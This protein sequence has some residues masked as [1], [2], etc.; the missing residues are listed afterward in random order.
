MKSARWQNDNTKFQELSFSSRRGALAN[1]QGRPLCQPLN[2]ISPKNVCGAPALVESIQLNP[3]VQI[4]IY[5]INKISQNFS[6]MFVTQNNPLVA[7][8]LLQICHRHTTVS[9]NCALNFVIK[10]YCKNALRDGLLY[11]GERKRLADKFERVAGKIMFHKV[12]AACHF[13]LNATKRFFQAFQRRDEWGSWGPFALGRL[14]R[15]Y[16]SEDVS[17]CDFKFPLLCCR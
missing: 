4:R 17:N 11:C 1:N 8:I 2:Y 13:I 9:F 7:I 12:F 15:F 3:R 5:D 6:A 10:G 14:I 16:V